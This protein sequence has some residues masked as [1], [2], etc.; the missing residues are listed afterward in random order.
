M[1][2][3]KQRQLEMRNVAVHILWKMKYSAQEI[4]ILF[5]LTTSMIYEIIK[6]GRDK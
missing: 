1:P 2:K 6:K 3:L 5:D 4:A